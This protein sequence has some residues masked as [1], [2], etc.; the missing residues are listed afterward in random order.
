MAD[1]AGKSP[2]DSPAPLCVSV[3]AAA[4]LLS[5]NAAHLYRLCKAHRIGHKD[6]NGHH[7][8]TPDDFRTLAS[9][10]PGNP[11]WRAKGSA[12]ASDGA[13]ARRAIAKQRAALNAHRN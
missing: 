3:P 1:S 6:A 10:K 2:P 9:L 7:V 12:A 4:L 11:A 8:L 5:R 13:D